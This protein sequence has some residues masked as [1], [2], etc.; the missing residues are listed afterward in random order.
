MLN[1]LIK[2]SES[3]AGS[4]TV[5]VFEAGSTERD[6]ETTGA[7]TDAI[8]RICVRKAGREV[9]NIARALRTLEMRRDAIL[10]SGVGVSES[11]G[12]IR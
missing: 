7:S 3:A 10:R 12:W 9:A 6:G 4:L 11:I 8:V 5:E 2:D 1:V